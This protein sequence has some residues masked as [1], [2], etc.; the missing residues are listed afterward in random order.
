MAFSKNKEFPLTRLKVLL[1]RSIVG[2]RID[3][4]GLPNPA[5]K[6]GNIFTIKSVILI[7]ALSQQPTHQPINFLRFYIK[8]G[9]GEKQMAVNFPYGRG[10]SFYWRLWRAQTHLRSRRSGRSKFG[11]PQHVASGRFALPFPVVDLSGRH[12][13]P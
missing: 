11:R 1:H 12:V 4:R 6:I 13:R 5:T 2:A 10:S 3:F 8:G 9:V 7:M